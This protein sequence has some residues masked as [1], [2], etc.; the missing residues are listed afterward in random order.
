M[1][2]KFWYIIAIV[3]LFSGVNKV[4]AQAEDPEK[5]FKL[6]HDKEKLDEYM[7]ERKWKQMDKILDEAGE[8]FYVYRKKSF[9]GGFVYIAVHPDKYVHYQKFNEEKRDYSEVLNYEDFILCPEGKTHENYS[10]ANENSL[11]KN[12]TFI[13]PENNQNENAFYGVIPKP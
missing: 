10:I 3:T 4:S 1:M 2:K 7:K 6:S 13:D 9:G 11:I 12:I 5:V 8:E